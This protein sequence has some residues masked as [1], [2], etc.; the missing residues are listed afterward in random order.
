[1]VTGLRTTIT[2]RTDPLC[3]YAHNQ[4]GTG[5]H[6]EGQ[7]ELVHENMNATNPWGRRGE[8]PSTGA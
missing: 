8:R 1:M 7:L 2:S 6:Q 4:S 5:K 3:H